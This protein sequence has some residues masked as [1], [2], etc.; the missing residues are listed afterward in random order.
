MREQA[1][2]FCYSRATHKPAEVVLTVGI[3]GSG[4]STALDALDATHE[5]LCPDDERE[6]LYGDA[7]EQG[8]PGEVHAKCIA[9]LKHALRRGARVA[10][11]ATNVRYELRARVLRVCH[12]YGARVALW[13]FDTPLDL[14]WICARGSCAIQS[15]LQPRHWRRP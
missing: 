14:A 3:S 1:V 2:A 4:K 9:R 5:R 12:D 8:N 13:C 7:S 6:A 11:D 15:G 10:Y